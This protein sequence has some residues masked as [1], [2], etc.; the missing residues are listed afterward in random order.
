MNLAAS[1]PSSYSVP[2][3]GSVVPWDPRLLAQEGLVR[4]VDAI[5]RKGHK[6]VVCVSLQFSCN[7]HFRHCEKFADVRF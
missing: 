6:Q 5:R 7:E 1:S 4:L 2:Q 3:K